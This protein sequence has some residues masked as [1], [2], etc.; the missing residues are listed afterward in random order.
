MHTSRRRQ[1]AGVRLAYTESVL[2]RTR[3]SILLRIRSRQQPKHGPNPHARTRRQTGIRRFRHRLFEVFSDLSSPRDSSPGRIEPPTPPMTCMGMQQG[4]IHFVCIVPRYS[5]RL[6]ILVVTVLSAV[7]G[8]EAKTRPHI[9]ISL[10][11][12]A[13]KPFAVPKRRTLSTY[14]AGYFPP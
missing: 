7:C 10:F 13:G 4:A 9:G 14:C 5:V 1:L 6:V 2:R 12:C 8:T 11:P 3:V